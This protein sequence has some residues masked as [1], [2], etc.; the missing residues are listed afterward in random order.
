ML[1]DQQLIRCSYD[2]IHIVGLDTP[3]QLRK[4]KM[5][6]GVRLK[7]LRR[8][9]RER[10]ILAQYVRELKLP[11]TL[12]DPDGMSEQEINVAASIVMSCPNLERLVNFYPVYRHE[13]N[14]LNHAL[15]TRR[16]LKEHVWVIGEN[17]TITARSHKQLPPG[18][19]DPEQA[20]SFI[21]YHANWQ[22]LTTLVMSSQH[23]AILEHH[24]LCRA[25]S[26]LP[27]LE[28]LHAASFDPDDF[29][30]ITLLSLPPLRSLR[31][32][33]LPGI[34]ASGLARYASQ[35]ASQ[36]LTSLSLVD[37][38]IPSLLTIS[39][40][41]SS[42]PVLASFT[43]SLSMAPILPT[44][45][46]YIP[47]LLASASLTSLHWQIHPPPEC[48]PHL[49]TAHLASSIE[50]NGFPSLRLLRCP[51]DPSGFLQCLCR[52]RAQIALP[53]DKYT[54]SP[55]PRSLHAARTAAQ[56]RLETARL[57]PAFR[58][59]VHN[60]E[61]QLY[62]VDDL[63]GFCGTI[64]TLLVYSLRSALPGAEDAL[65]QVLDLRIGEGRREREGRDCCTGLW[66][67]SHPV[68]KKWWEHQSR[69]RWRGW[70]VEKLF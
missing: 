33:A 8:T 38:L 7:L 51:N 29:N 52:P 24:I 11:N 23:N 14:R 43:L 25:L 69:P 62:S 64:G 68:G 10:R 4:Y 26:L 60:D 49:A 44:D 61:G 54:P 15:S 31:L 63:P 17:S 35:P 59:L 13:F 34:T 21:S 55:S 37:L 5:K 50:A 48:D 66:N 9:L 27:S 70:E 22:S 45:A 12:D 53:A 58:L 16:K 20:S 57:Y 28:N 65:A 46:F 30:D 41:L 42:L 39:K 1:D 18:L 40:I 56:K 19:M 32:Q 36:S 2:R 47:P 67:A 3:L 6:A